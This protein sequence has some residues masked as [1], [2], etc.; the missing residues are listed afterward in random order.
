MVTTD[1]VLAVCGCE[2]ATLLSDAKSVDETMVGVADDGTAAS[3]AS[4]SESRTMTTGDAAESVTRLLLLG[5]AA[6]DAAVHG[7]LFT[8]VSLAS[9]TDFT[10]RS[11]LKCVRKGCRYF[12]C[13]VRL[14][15]L[16]VCNLQYNA[17]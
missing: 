2:E 9:L 14:P 8:S 17:C 5:N 6:S 12:Y 10:N 3:S 13:V 11:I 4:Q 15:E 7:V 1:A 16:S